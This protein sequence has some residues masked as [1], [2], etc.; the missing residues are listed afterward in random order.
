MKKT[1]RLGE[2]ILEYTHTVSVR[3]RNIRL[4]IDRNGEITVSSPRFVPQKIIEIFLRDK[5][6]WIQEKVEYFKK[7][8]STYPLLDKAAAYML[9]EEHKDRALILV[10]SKLGE[11]N[12]IYNFRW[13]R[14]TI[15]DTKTRWGSCSKEGNLN[16]SYKIALLPE[17]LANYIVVHELC[18]LGEF[19]HSKNFWNMVAKTIPDYKNAKEELKKE[20]IVMM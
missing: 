19:N 4:A 1:I 3:T 2:Q 17:H 15:K 13:N 14:V 16:F 5:S 8:R 11:Y 18:H 10:L 7:I 20:G 6:L 9:Y 12:K